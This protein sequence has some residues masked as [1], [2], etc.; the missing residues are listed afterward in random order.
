MVEIKI[1][2]N[3]FSDRL[4]I[5]IDDELPK[6]TSNLNKNDKNFEEWINEL[7]EIL[8]EECNT[9]TF[10]ITFY[11]SIDDYKVLER[12]LEEANKRGFKFFD[13]ELEKGDSNIEKVEKGKKIL[14]E[15]NF[16]CKTDAYIR[17][18][19]ET[20]KKDDFDEKTANINIDKEVFSRLKESIDNIEKFI[21]IEISDDENIIERLFQ[22]NK[23]I[24][25]DIEE[26][27]KQNIAID[28][29][30]D[31]IMK[32]NYNNTENEAEVLIKEIRDNL[33]KIGKIELKDIAANELN[34]C[35]D[36]ANII[37]EKLISKEKV[38]ERL[39]AL[40]ISEIVKSNLIK[41]SE[42]IV[43]EYNKDLEISHKIISL[44]NND[45]MFSQK[46]WLTAKSKVNLFTKKVYRE[47]IK[48]KSIIEN[49]A[50]SILPKS[51]MLPLT[52]YQKISGD[53]CCD[54]LAIKDFDRI[55]IKEVLSNYEQNKNEIDEYFLDILIEIQ[56][57]IEK[58]L[59]KLD[60]KF[61]QLTLLSLL[62]FVIQNKIKINIDRSKKRLVWLLG[63]KEDINLILN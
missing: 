34:I 30:N 28:K 50:E 24:N 59:I 63:I 2:Y 18:L 13:L 60:E 23:N 44:F 4:E 20:F 7:P 31:L 62:N 5:K 14:E 37:L 54:I 41:E 39:A 58:I 49:V 21:N 8:L 15:I 52:L 26:I 29:F 46:D 36:D 53:N 11:G 6:A 12:V 45:F 16:R 27:K 3:S 47:K 48:P 33:I 1:R 43:N 17:E 55:L 25:K 51:V 32:D 9:K 38:F 57:N 61:M 19:F 22:K 42:K 35:L 40:E 56:K 10:K